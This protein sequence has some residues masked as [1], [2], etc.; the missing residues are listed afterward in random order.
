MNAPDVDASMCPIVCISYILFE[1]KHHLTR[2]EGISS[3]IA[4]S[5]DQYIFSNFSIRSIWRTPLIARARNFRSSSQRR[6]RKKPRREVHR[7]LLD[8]SV[9]VRVYPVHGMNS[10]RAMCCWPIRSFRAES[11][12]AHRVPPCLSH[13]FFLLSLSLSPHGGSHHTTTFPLGPTKSPGRASSLV[14]PFIFPP[15]PLPS[16]VPR[17]LSVPTQRVFPAAPG[18]AG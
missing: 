17:P 15:P 4:L 8:R 14:H 1:G 12:A 13:L 3:P 5:P 9:R 2:I 6:Y 16:Y 11:H 18:A 10:V 7:S